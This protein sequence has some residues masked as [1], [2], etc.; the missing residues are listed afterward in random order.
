MTRDLPKIQGVRHMTSTP[1]PHEQFLKELR[2]EFAGILDQTSQGVYLYLD[3]PHWICNDRLATMLG[4][5]SAGELRKAAGDS[6][7]LDIAVASESQQRVVDAYMGVVNANVA[8]SIPVTWMK[9]DGSMLKTQT[10]FAP[11]SFQGTVLPIHFV[12]PI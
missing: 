10:I 2:G 1:H 3:D 4:Y 12:T 9:K 8:S 5:A 11:I 7:F 6:Q